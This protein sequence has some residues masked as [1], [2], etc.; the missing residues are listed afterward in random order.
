MEFLD[1]LTT[2]GEVQAKASAIWLITGV[3]PDIERTENKVI[4]RLKPE[5]ITKMRSRFREL[6][7]S[8]P[9]G[10]EVDLKPV[11]LPVLWEKYWPY[12]IGIPA[13]ILAL[14]FIFGKIK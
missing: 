13:G 3:Y 14:G 5:Q 6:L 11:L 1:I 9:S 10:V 8:K 2:E 7:D 12:V 4:I